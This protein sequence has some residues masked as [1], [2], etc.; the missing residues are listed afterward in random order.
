MTSPQTSLIMVWITPKPI[1]GMYPT[2]DPLYV[3]ATRWPGTGQM[4]IAPGS[5]AFHPRQWANNKTTGH[6]IICLKECA[7]YGRKAEAF[8]GVR[9]SVVRVCLQRATVPFDTKF[10]RWTIRVDRTVILCAFFYPGR[11]PGLVY[12]AL[13]GLY[14]QPVSGWSFDEWTLNCP[15]IYARGPGNRTKHPAMV[16]HAKENAPCMAERQK[17]CQG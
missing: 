2:L 15:G 9:C 3:G 4:S 16:S 5:I 10:C 7:M 12:S 13:S 11:C 8:S 1:T 14:G 17:P 6:G